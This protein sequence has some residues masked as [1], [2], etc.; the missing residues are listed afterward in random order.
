MEEVAPHIRRLKMP[1]FG[2]SVW[3]VSNVY[4]VGDDELL[5]I[6]AGYPTH[7]SIDSIL[8]AWR[9]LG[10]PP[11]KAI[12][13]THAHLDHIGALEAIKKETGAPAWAHHL[14]AEFFIEMFPQ[15]RIDEI[16][17]DGDEIEA[18]KFRL[19]VL[20][21]PGH[22]SGHLCFLDKSSGSLFTGDLVV[23]NSFAII[24]PPSGDMKKYMESLHRIEE[25]PLRRLLP[26]HG[27]PIGDPKAKIEEYIVHRIL[28]EM[29][30]LKH[31]ENG[32]K[33]IPEMAEDIYADMH[34]V[35]RKA[36]RL[37]VLAHLLKMDAEG[38]VEIVSGE[39]TDAI[40]RSL[41]GE[42]PF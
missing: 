14:E 37:Q 32:P 11:V 6:D 40:Y 31:L 7:E 5:L 34:T 20:H 42:L 4:F 21:M 33:S 38:Q 27:P 2:P 29:Q 41:I 24:V 1:P 13:I 18:G 30:I 35:L 28:R 16:I 10:C 17:D 22:T 15:E 9:N 8:G 26:G 25:M 36:G 12:L 23:G 19:S 3:E 39:G